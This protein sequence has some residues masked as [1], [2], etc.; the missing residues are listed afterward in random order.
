MTPSRRVAAIK[1]RWK[2]LRESLR[3]DIDERTLH[4]L[5]A[6]V[7]DDRTLARPR[8]RRVRASDGTGAGTGLAMFAAQGE[9][10]YAEVMGEPPRSDLAEVSPLPHL[11]PLLTQ[12]GEQVPWLRVIVN[13]V[14]ADI[15]GPTNDTI[16][17]EGTHLFPIRKTHG[18]GWSQEHLHRKA[19]LRWQ[20]NAKEVAEQVNRFADSRRRRAG[21]R[22]RRR[23]GPATADRPASASAGANAWSRSRRVRARPVRI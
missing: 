21:D 17:V 8:E 19:E 20:H 5:D 15:E 7:I 3:H 10:R 14:G 23:P 6:E 9:V 2:D 13:R 4:A 18:G 22:R 12:R 16:Q 1:I 11:T